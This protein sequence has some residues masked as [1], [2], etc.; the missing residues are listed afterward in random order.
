MHR[1]SRLAAFVIGAIVLTGCFGGAASQTPTSSTPSQASAS[2]DEVP[3]SAPATAAAS[4][5]PSEEALGPFTCDLPIHV[6]ATV[7]RANITDVRA[8]TH[9]GYDRVVFEFTDGLPEVFVERASPPFTQDASGEPLTVEG[10]S[11]VRL[12]LRGGTKQVESDG[13]SSYEGPT[14]FDPGFP[15][16][17]DLLEGGDFE[18]QSTWYLGLASEACVRVLQLVGEGGMARLVIDV[19]Q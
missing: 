2:Q 16:L 1:P 12:T 15:M 7:A 8:G 11:F 18:A 9:A 6:D 5:A 4:A 17:V 19:E 14:D 3:A 10:S 13:S